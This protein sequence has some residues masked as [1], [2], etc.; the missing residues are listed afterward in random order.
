MDV[1]LVDRSPENRARLSSVIETIAGA[2][3]CGHASTAAA[4]IAAILGTKPDV[5]LLD[6]NLEEGS[7]FQVLRE[8]AA[9]EPGIALYMLSNYASEPYR[10]HARRMGALDFFDRTTELERLRA[11]LAARSLATRQ[12]VAPL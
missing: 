12:P 9:R 10:R 1:Y 7:G 4:A 11:M 8:V 5:V 3:V 6:V 2:H